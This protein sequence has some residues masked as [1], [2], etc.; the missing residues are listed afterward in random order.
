MPTAAKIEDK[1]QLPAFAVK[2]AIYDHSTPQETSRAIDAV[3]AA[4]SRQEASAE[5]L[6]VLLG[7]LLVHVQDQ[8]LFEPEYSSFELFTQ[9]VTERHRMSRATL[10][11]ALMIARRLPGITPEQA[12][13]IPMTSLALVARAAKNA[14]PRAVSGM[15]RH[16]ANHSVAE[17]REHTMGL[18][19]QKKQGGVIIR[20]M[21]TAAVAKRWKALAGDDAGAA[22]A[23]LVM[24]GVAKAA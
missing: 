16:A 15:L 20:L 23:A 1:C 2:I 18:V 3:C 10:R 12:E 8:R 14:D 24:G 11:E 9:S 17:V 13:D 7:R 21:V 22:F 19:P 5:R 6:R 4:M